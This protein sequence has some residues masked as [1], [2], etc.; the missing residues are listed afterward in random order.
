MNPRSYI[1]AQALGKDALIAGDAPVTSLVLA[2]YFQIE[3]DTPNAWKFFKQSMELSPDPTIT[4]PYFLD[5][6]LKLKAAYREEM[7]KQKGR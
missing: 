4:D 6:Y 3:G 1:T 5:A 2:S 7:S